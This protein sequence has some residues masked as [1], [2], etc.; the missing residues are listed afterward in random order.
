MMAK[1]N[2]LHGLSIT[3]HDTIE[4]YPE[5]IAV[6]KK[7]G[8]RLVSGVELS[9]QF[10][11]ESLHLLGYDFQLEHPAM[12]QLCERHTLRRNNRNRAILEKLHAKK[13]VISEEELS[14][15]A[16]G[17]AAGRA[18]IALLLCEKGYVKTPREAFQ[19][20][21]GEGK[22]C[23]VQGEAFDPSEAISI[24]HQAQGKAFIAHPHLLPDLISLESLL[25]LPFDGIE[26]YYSRLTAKPWLEIAKARGLLVSGGSD[27]HGTIRPEVELGCNG[28]D[29][30][31]FEQIFER[32]PTRKPKGDAF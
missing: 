26:C 6:A 21:I 29:Q 20:Y 12:H 30:A 17:H 28:V 14:F 1:K 3:D 15:K 19:K 18:H 5:A 32:E 11:G 9:C 10:E 8:I 23:F 7:V 2:G 31:T 27:F 13:M 25:K 24:L 22:E 16:K 4:A